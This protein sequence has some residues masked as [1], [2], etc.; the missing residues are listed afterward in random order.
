MNS[1]KIILTILGVLLIVGSIFIAKTIIDNKKRP[2][3]QIQRSIKT[4]FVDTVQNQ[5]VPIVIESNG[6]LLAKERVELYSEVQ[7]V[8]RSSSKPFKAGQQFSKGESLLRI[9]DVE[10]YS[11]VMAQRSNFYNL[12]AAT[13]PDL[14]LDF[15]DVA[16]KW[17]AYLNKIDVNNSL[18]TLPEM[19]SDKEKYFISGRGIVSNYYTIKN[20]ENRLSKYRIRAPFNGVLTQASVN[21]GTLVRSGQKLGEFIN[22]R[23]YE[24][25]VAITKTYGYLLKEGEQVELSDLE[26]TKKWTG[27]VVRVNGRVNPETQTVS[28]FVDVKA[29]DLKEGMYLKAFVR[30]KEEN[31]AIEVPRKLLLENNE[32]FVVNDTVLEVQKVNPVYFSEKTVVLKGLEDGTNLLAEPVPGAYPGMLVKIIERQNSSNGAVAKSGSEP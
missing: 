5:T 25:E 32:V 17:Q 16:P 3:S 22:P 28:A 15:P 12:L 4:V 11:S 27:T 7:G 24:L 8:L 10:F 9:D 21:E 19:S 1:R 23:I 26:G 20:L 31:D 6:N 18:P 14:N 13:M 2:E 30:A 29:D